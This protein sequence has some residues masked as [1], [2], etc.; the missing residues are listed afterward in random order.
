MDPLT[1]TGVS[2]MS[3]FSTTAVHLGSFWRD[4][5]R[6]HRPGFPHQK[7]DYERRR[8]II[9]E[10]KTYQQGLFYFLANDKRVPEEVRTRASEWGLAADEFPDHWP[11]QLY[12]REARRMIGSYLMTENELLKRRPTPDSV[13]MG[14]YTIDS[15]NTQRHVAIEDGVHRVHN[16]GDI[17]VG[18]R[19][20]KLQFTPPSAASPSHPRSVRHPRHT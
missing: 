14:S 1:P 9:E 4:A 11:H 17:G 12:I 20:I 8:E 10:H 19:R 7:A 15:H 3:V 18:L 13:G 6:G 16:E 5:R 2:V